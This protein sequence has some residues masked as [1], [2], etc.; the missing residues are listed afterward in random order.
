VSGDDKK[1]YDKTG[2]K[3]KKYSSDGKPIYED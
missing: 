1:R 2:K 3:V